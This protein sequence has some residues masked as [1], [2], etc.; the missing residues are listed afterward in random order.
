MEVDFVSNRVAK[1]SRSTD[2]MVAEAIEIAKARPFEYDGRKLMYDDLSTCMKRL[3]D[4]MYRRIKILVGTGSSTRCAIDEA[5][6]AV[7]R[8]YSMHSMA[9][10][11]QAEDIVQQTLGSLRVQRLL[12]T[13]HNRMSR[14]AANTSKRTP[15]RALKPVAAH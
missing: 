6:D 1:F 9:S 8:E 2:Q 12:H 10:R 5:I 3:V 15:H 7:C 11:K 14:P 4:E 13:A